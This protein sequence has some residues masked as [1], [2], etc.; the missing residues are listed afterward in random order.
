IAPLPGGRL[1]R[2]EARPA[3]VIGG[4]GLPGAR[5]LG[6]GRRAR[7]AEGERHQSGPQ[8]QAG[9]ATHYAAPSRVNIVNKG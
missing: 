4:R 9:C 6:A 2:A 3:L 5:C 7:R 8:E 1:E